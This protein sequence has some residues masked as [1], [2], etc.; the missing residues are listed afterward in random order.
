MSD[1]KRDDGGAA[2]PQQLD[3]D[4]EFHGSDGM[5]LRDYFAGQALI[6]M[7]AMNTDVPV[8]VL[9]RSERSQFAQHAYK[10]ADA[11]LAERAK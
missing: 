11:M 9:A 10:M 3:V 8:D 1:T 2:F 6:G 5:S 4:H 7:F